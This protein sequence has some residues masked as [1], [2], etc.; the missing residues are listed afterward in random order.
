MRCR[1]QPRPPAGANKAIVAG[2]L[3]QEIPALAGNLAAASR[4]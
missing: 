4:S 1:A 3:I 2:A